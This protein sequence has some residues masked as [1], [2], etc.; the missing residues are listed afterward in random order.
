MYLQ[1]DTSADYSERRRETMKEKV[2]RSI[3]VLLAMSVL[4]LLVPASV[5]AFEAVKLGEDS[6]IAVYGFFRNNAAIFMQENQPYAQSDDRMAAMRFMGRG[7]VDYKINN[8][9]RFWSAVQ[10]AF[11]PWYPIERNANSSAGTTGG[12]VKENGKEYSEFNDIN[13]SLREVLIEW[14][15]TKGNSIKI[16]RQ[17]AIWGEAMTTRVGDVIHPDNGRGGFV[18]AA[19][20]DSRIPQWMV[21]GVHDILPL[22][23]SFEWI[24]NPNFTARQ[25]SVNRSASLITTV[26]T[27]EQR[28][29]LYPED[30]ATAS[31]FSRDLPAGRLPLAIPTVVTEYPTDTFED[32]RAGFRTNTTMGGYTFGMTYWHTQMYTPVVQR[33][34][35]TGVQIPLGPFI[36]VPQREF[37]VYYPNIDI[38]G[39]YMNK[40]WPPW[41]GVVRAEA[42]YIPNNAFGTFDPTNESAVVRT[43]YIKYM[44]AYDLNSFLYFPW[45]KDAAFDVTFE[46]V[47]EWIPSENNLQFA[48]YNTELWRWMPSFNMRVS[49]SWLY[50]MI[51]T[52]CILSWSA[53]GNS[54]L[55]MPG[56]NYK[57]PWANDQL[58]FALTYVNISA[59]D[60]YQGIG[61]LR[62]KD[63]LQLTTQFN[64]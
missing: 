4:A 3:T 48:V 59:K 42:I 25:Y 39:A 36:R 1:K 60:Y 24:V 33:R 8:Q 43:D 29:S 32:T 9:L 14:R 37:R 56:V 35:L 41:P 28:F 64:W 7:Y 23:S 50:G 38:F 12:L 53:Y 62:S 18:F 17:I 61:I 57:V 26:G 20:E 49:T 51:G 63:L 21:R 58:T 40:N 10:G 45:H 44:F 34:G 11:E 13:D 2:S 16:G 54:W 19:L 47:G 55:I 15:P 30:R 22:R 31:P 6:E 46:H 52:D 5:S 27:P